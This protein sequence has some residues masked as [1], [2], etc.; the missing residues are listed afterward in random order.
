MAV[1]ERKIGLSQEKFALSI[2]DNVDKTYCVLVEYEKN[3]SLGNIKKIA[4]DPNNSMG[5]I[6]NELELYTK[7]NTNS[8]K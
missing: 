2:N 8:Y 4:N 1:I 5:T 6:F 3:I 7:N